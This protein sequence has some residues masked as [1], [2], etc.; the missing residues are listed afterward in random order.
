MSLFSAINDAV[1]NVVEA[2][3]GDDGLL[4]AALDATGLGQVFDA[5]GLDQLV[6]GS[7]GGF[8][9]D[10]MDELGLPDVVGDLVGTF[11]DLGMGNTLGAT[12][13]FVD[14][15]EDIAGGLGVD[16][17]VSD[18]AGDAG[19]AALDKGLSVVGEEFMN[20]IA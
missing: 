14:A 13:N 16:E 7:V 5:F 20:W 15:L 6:S 2:V 10:L 17:L 18:I 4:G 11:V 8:I 3:A 9:N 12:S 19:D 1:S